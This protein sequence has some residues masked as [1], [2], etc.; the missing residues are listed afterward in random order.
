MRLQ[1][2]LGN[3]A[4]GQLV[5]SQSSGLGHTV[6]QRQDD[7][8]E[9]GAV[10]GRQTQVLTPARL[11]NYE[12][13]AVQLER[14]AADAAG[15]LG[16][17]IEQ[18][19]AAETKGQRLTIDALRQEL[20]EAFAKIRGRAQ[21]ISTAMQGRSAEQPGAASAL[22][23]ITEIDR[24]FAIEHE[25][26]RA[27]LAA[28]IHR[29][30]L[31]A[32][33]ST[34]SQSEL[35]EVDSRSNRRNPSVTQSD[36]REI[37][38]WVGGGWSTLNR[39]MF[40]IEKEDDRQARQMVL[41]QP[42]PPAGEARARVEN[43]QWQMNLQARVTG[44]QAA[45]TKLPK[46]GGRT[47]RQATPK[48]AS[49]Y[50]GTIKVGDFIQSPGFFATSMLRGG[51]GAA[52]GSTW[53]KQ[54]GK[55]YFQVTGASG[56]DLGPYQET[57]ASEREVLYPANAV[58]EVK[59]IEKRGAA[60]FVILDQVLVVPEGATVREPF[61]GELVRPPYAEMADEQHADELDLV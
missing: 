50:G 14:T 16:E 17:L 58:F 46:Y 8:D 11:P 54:A 15:R 39:F 60:V 5:A 24:T 53:G 2:T 18:E 32:L 12:R 40:G 34:S 55:A 35:G 42:L 19:Q 33:A 57:L 7:E 21:E 10:G 41:D 51:G 3:R 56:R 48:D 25:K 27:T 13:E 37:Q 28:N 29:A 44:L 47:Y 20:V 1:R 43:N 22:Q 36:V 45:L 6:V 4:V 61:A 9:E 31:T 26:F 49:V 52:G 59:A 23:T 30:E 38:N